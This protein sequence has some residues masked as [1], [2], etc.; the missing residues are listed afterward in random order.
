MTAYYPASDGMI[1]YRS[2][3]NPDN[4]RGHTADGVVIDEI[5]YVKQESWYEVLRQMLMDTGGWMWG[6]GTPNGRNWF[7]RE[8]RAA[9]D[10][11][12]SASWQ[13][14][15]V[16]CEIVD[17]KL[18]RK[19]HPM[20]NPFIAWDEIV[21]QFETLPL[22]IFKQEILAEF[23]EGEGAVFRN[24]LAC[25]NAPTNEDPVMHAGQR[26][27]VVCGVDWGKQQD[28]TTISVGCAT[29]KIELARD[30]FNKI[31]YHFQ[32]DRLA[33]LIKMWGV[34]QA[35]IELNSVGEPNFEELQRSGLPVIAFTTTAS[36]KPALIENLSLVLDKAEWQFQNDP[37][38]TGEL[39]AYERI[40]S[41]T[42]GRSSYSA[43]E[44]L[45]DDT[46]LAR[47]LMV[48]AGRTGTPAVVQPESR[49]KW[50]GM[51]GENDNGSRW[52]I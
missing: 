45:N 33:R 22:D 6:I 48:W 30:R 10:R 46:V 50:T 32:R 27:R 37:I 13:V 9:L 39:E 8:H 17:N 1:V 21:N 44:N 18:V 3:D 31:D 40:V 35:L 49:S 29:C 5:G 28:F 47:A 25:I 41:P 43:P 11:E 23:L 42:T 4:A 36:T 51:A 7:F 2:L 19:V 34:Q 15:T 12:D 38:W 52:R 14:P 24:I 26:H 16:G 20:E